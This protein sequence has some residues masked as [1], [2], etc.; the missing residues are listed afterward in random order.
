MSAVSPND[1][2][3]TERREASRCELLLTALAVTFAAAVLLAAGLSVGL[4]GLL[5]LIGVPA[6]LGL[7]YLL[8]QVDPAYILCIGFF[9]TPF[10]GN[11]K[12]MHFPSG[13]D[14]ERMFLLFGVAQVLLRAPKIK[15]RPRFRWT[16]A[17]LFM[18]FAVIYAAISAHLAGRLFSKAPLFKLT[19]DF[20]L[21]PFMIFLVAPVAFRT[22]RH[23][24]VLLFT[25]V[26]MGLYLGVTT[27]FETVHLNALVYPR[28]ILDPKVGYNYGR[29]RGPFV[30]A[31]ANGF[32]LAVCAVG[33]GV[34]S[35]NWSQPR[36]RLA[37]IAVGVLAV[38]GAFMSLERSVWL[39]AGLGIL[40]TLS[41]TRRLRRYLI[42]T[43]ALAAV[44]VV[45]SLALISSFSNSVSSRATQQ[46]SI[47]DRENL[48]A[49][50]FRMLEQ[51][52]LL[53]F[54]WQTFQ[55]KSRLYFQQNQNYP[56][57]ATTFVVHN[58]LLGY[59]VDLGLIGLLLWVASVVFGIGSALV[60]R[61]PPDIEMWHAGLIAITVLFIVVANSIPPS[62]F[63]NLSLWVWAGVG[64]S[65]RYATRP[66]VTPS[67]VGAPP[68]PLP[69]LPQ[70]I[71]VVARPAG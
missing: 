56:L 14:P 70:E 47:W 37:A 25:M 33:C 60:A 71:G 36:A 39:G 10:A 34:A 28:Y 31:V 50:G 30:D 41:V 1:E 5:I 6:L 15:G 22:Q 54:G 58:F 21:T 27:L 18:A 51:R 19:D 16:A 45:T 38:L 68:E 23:R 69:L 13:I 65:G 20:G 46:S 52:P 3:H 43:A 42:P 2:A 9:L 26:V 48:L 8:W 66:W 4:D 62:E 59:A 63:P 55:S 61:G 32:A 12:Y 24:S 53:G 40:V 11:W 35:M 57:T 67:S 7:V 64:Y 49:A 44:V 17:H 29:G